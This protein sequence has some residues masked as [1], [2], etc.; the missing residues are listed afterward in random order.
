MSRQ[1]SWRYEIL[2]KVQ[3]SA[4]LKIDVMKERG[5]LQDI[6]NHYLKKYL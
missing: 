1:S 3:F 5:E 6:V 2:L 4:L